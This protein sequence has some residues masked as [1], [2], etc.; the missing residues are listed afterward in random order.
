MVEDQL[1]LSH[2]NATLVELAFFFL[3]YLSSIEG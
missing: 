1:E 2:R 3:I